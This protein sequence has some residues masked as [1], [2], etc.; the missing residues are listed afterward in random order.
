MTLNKIVP[1]WLHAICAATSV[2]LAVGLHST[3]GSPILST[4]TVT[5]FAVGMAITTI[6]RA[7]HDAIAS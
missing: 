4:Y 7:I 1:L 5:G 6:A 3:S 2:G